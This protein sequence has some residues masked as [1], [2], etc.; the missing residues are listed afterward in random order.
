MALIAAAQAAWHASTSSTVTS[1][2]P[3]SG[4]ATGTGVGAIDGAL[5]S[6]ETRVWAVAASTTLL[7]HFVFL[8][9]IQ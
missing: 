6:R 4:T 1:S 7:F 2:S 9:F 8:Y 3:A 5:T